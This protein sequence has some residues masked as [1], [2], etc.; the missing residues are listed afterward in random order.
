M[1]QEQVLPRV[2]FSIEHKLGE[3]TILRINSI[4]RDAF[5]EQLVFFGIA[6]APAAE[7]QQPAP[8]KEVAK[9][10]PKPAKAAKAKAAAPAA[11][12]PAA[13]APTASAE[14]APAASTTAPDVKPED[15]AAAVRSYGAANGIDAARAKLIGLGLK[16][17]KEITADNAATVLAA[18]NDSDEEL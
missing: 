17:T 8:A 7:A 14:T 4:D 6:Q 3:Q 16:S 10:A 5:V 13:S 11:E 1:N 9:E 12:T 18:F 15:A 2:A